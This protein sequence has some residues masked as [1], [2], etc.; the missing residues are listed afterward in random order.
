MDT[1]YLLKE[2][3]SQENSKKSNAEKI[4]G[5]AK[6]RKFKK[7]QNQENSRKSKAEKIQGKAMLRK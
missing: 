3:Q 2:K 4:Q 5:I 7:K 1:T 6:P